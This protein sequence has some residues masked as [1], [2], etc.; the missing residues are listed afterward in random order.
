[1]EAMN[2][3]LC[4]PTCRREFKSR[5]ALRKC[6]KEHD[7]AEERNLKLKLTVEQKGYFQNLIQCLILEQLRKR[8]S[9]AVST[10]CTEEQFL[11]LFYHPKMRVT[12]PKTI[13][14]TLVG[15][16]ARDFLEEKLG[17]DSLTFRS[18][19]RANTLLTHLYSQM[20]LVEQEL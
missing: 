3:L 17:S 1:M 5:A 14:L 6:G 11:G 12:P 4:C 18:E 9:G 15:K 19:R 10:P 2:V 16:E 20:Q 8:M 7:E 13:S